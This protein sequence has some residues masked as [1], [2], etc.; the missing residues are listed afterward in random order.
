MLGSAGAE[1]RE[2]GLGSC[3]AFGEGFE[4]GGVW[5]FAGPWVMIISGWGGLR[6]CLF[7]G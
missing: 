7:G 4:D 5:V 2:A 6:L 1:E 3:E